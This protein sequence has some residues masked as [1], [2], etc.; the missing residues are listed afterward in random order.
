MFLGLLVHILFNKFKEKTI[1]FSRSPLLQT[2][3][4]TDS[5]SPPDGVGNN[6]SRTV[7]ISC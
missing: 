7:I 5:K 1:F 4:I 2:L 6:G 3:G